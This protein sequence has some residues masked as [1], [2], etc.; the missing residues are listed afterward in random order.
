MIRSVD[1]HLFFNFRSP[2]CYLASKRMFQL[3]DDYHVRLMWRPLGGWHGRSAPDRAKIKVPITRQDVRRFARKMG[4]PVNP[5]PSTT[6]PTL[7]AL[8]SLVAEERGRLRAYVVEVM[9]HEW[10][11]GQD[12]GDRDVLSRIAESVGLDRSEVAAAFED[13]A[14]SEQLEANWREAQEK[15]VMGVP[16]WVVGDEIFWGNDRLEFVEDHLRELALARL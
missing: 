6:D 12:I 7:A 2:Y 1:L 10:A 8:G 3:L 14:L 16:T 13:P 4:I 5:P 15:G 11:M 9:R